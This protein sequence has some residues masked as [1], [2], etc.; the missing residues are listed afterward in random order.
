MFDVAYLGLHD[1]LS[2]I[3]TYGTGALLSANAVIG[4]RGVQ[5]GLASGLFRRSTNT[6]F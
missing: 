3:V 6:G 5:T 1:G 4:L 2:S